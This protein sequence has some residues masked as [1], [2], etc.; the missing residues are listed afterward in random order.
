M[1]VLDHKC[2]YFVLI[3]ETPHEPRL[4]YMSLPASLNKK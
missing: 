4:S 2:L 3:Y 1:H